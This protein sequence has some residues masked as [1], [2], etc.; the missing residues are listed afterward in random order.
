MYVSVIFEL[1]PLFLQSSKQEAAKLTHQLKKEI[2]KK[3]IKKTLC[4]HRDYV[5][6]IVLLKLSFFG[7]REH[8]HPESPKC[9]DSLPV[10]QL[11]LYRLQLWVKNILYSVL[12]LLNIFIFFLHFQTTDGP[13]HSFYIPVFLHHFYSPHTP[14]LSIALTAKNKSMTRLCVKRI[15]YTNRFWISVQQR[16]I[17]QPYSYIV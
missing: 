5:L 8:K 16:G 14:L 12:F 9:S 6:Y 15:S 10:L 11:C 4:G 17:V 13:A 1:E 2:N 7:V 3:N